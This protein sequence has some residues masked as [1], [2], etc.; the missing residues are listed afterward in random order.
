MSLDL[1]FV[2]AQFPALSSTDWVYMDNAGGSLTLKRVAD[3]VSDYL[4]TTSV[5]HGASYEISARAKE[6]LEE[7]RGSVAKL[8]QARESREIVFGPSSTVLLKF[9][10]LAMKSQFSPGDEVIV[11]NVD[12]EANIGP[13][14]HLEEAGA[15]IRF[16]NV[17][18]ESLR[19]ETKDLK[20]LLSSK[21]R[22][23]CV[24]QTS[25]VLGT[26]EPIQEWSK[27]VHD[28][29][30]QICIDGV[31]FAPHRRI[32]VKN[33]DVDYYVF[34]LYKVYGPHMGALYGKAERLLALD[35]IGHF[36][37]GK[38]KIPGKLEPGNPTYEIAYG[39]GG[40]VDYLEELGNRCDPSGSDPLTAA[41]DHI[42]AHEEIL[43][44]RLLA[45][46]TSRPTITVIGSKVADRAVRVPTL[47]FTVAGKSS[48]EIVES[49]DGHK[50][51]I[52]FGDF[53]AHRLIKDLELSSTNGV[54]RV[55]LAHYNTV[56]EV[57]RLV[58]VLEK[59]VG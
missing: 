3:R 46:L 56:K 5:Q 59:L 7:A 26:I 23:V 57:D 16:W 19:L 12:H 42:A 24:T 27:A 15:K 4:L 40:I 30:A 18:P 43:S 51:G 45:F 29:G 13:W 10:A 11:T 8:F 53:H 20:N 31:A 34:S 44:A 33:W 55:S 6:R 17:N 35:S 21:T 36:F 9:L 49:V 39:C 22:L 41:F 2:R 50:I 28:A 58:E 32:D 1:D 38:E 54:V 37:V 25:N 47:S 52:R 48:K 14:V